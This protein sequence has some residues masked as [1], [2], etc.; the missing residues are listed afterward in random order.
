MA[1]LPQLDAGAH[2][3]HDALAHGRAHGCVGRGA[4]ERRRRRVHQ[5][6]VQHRCTRLAWHPPRRPQPPRAQPCA[7]TA[8]LTHAWTAQA[9]CMCR[10]QMP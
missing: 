9:C 10:S 7:P 2:S 3:P 8:S 1:R 4:R 6:A 5:V